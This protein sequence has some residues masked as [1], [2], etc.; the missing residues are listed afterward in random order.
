MCLTTL[1]QVDLFD[2]RGL[3]VSELYKVPIEHIDIGMYIS[4]TTPGLL[5]VGFNTKGMISQRGT[6]ERLVLS[7]IKELYIDVSKGKRSDYSV[8]V[9]DKN[10]NTS[11]TKTLAD[12]RQ[13]AEKVYGEAVS[14]VGSLMKDVKMG[15]P[16]DVGPVEEL[17]DDINNSVLNNENA[18]LC[19]SQIREKDQYLLEHSINV[20]ILMGVLSRHLGFARDTVHQLVTGALLHDIGKIRVPYNVLNKPG[21]LNEDE[22][23]E[24]QRHVQYGQEVLLKSQGISDV[25]MS[26]CAQ[27]HERLD[28][29]GYPQQLK[30]KQINTY[31]RLASVVDIYDALTA[32][33]VYHQGKT[34][35][36]AMKILIT[37]GDNHL[38]KAFVYEFIR[39]M[40]VYPVGT[41][42]ELNNGKLGVVLQANSQNPSAPEV[43]VFFNF[44]HKHFE[45]PQVVDLAKKALGLTVVAAHDPRALNID[46]RDFL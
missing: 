25:A 43:R 13:N 7:G 21:K 30:G 6:I 2:I 17:A 35:F 34:P 44:K 5:D 39:C 46:I 9:R 10:H 33:R 12:E 23:V 19:L 24:M 18:L 41:L 14:L 16:I 1:K 42:V 29:T 31:G 8:P 4:E 11:A 45:N 22:W 28:G 15:N 40:S 37:L 38:D 3:F 27:H 26:I 32:D 20:G 36:E